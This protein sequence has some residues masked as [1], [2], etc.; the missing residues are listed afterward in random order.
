MC[1][2]VAVS[3]RG[4][5]VQDLFSAFVTGLDQ[6]TA[7]GGCTTALGFV[8]SPTQQQYESHDLGRAKVRR[9]NCVLIVVNANMKEAWTFH[10]GLSIHDAGLGDIYNSRPF[11][12]ARFEISE[13]IGMISYDHSNA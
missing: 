4:L 8:S 13:E 12:L 11:L 7:R 5:V 6:A 10:L 2:I 3:V 9:L 1:A